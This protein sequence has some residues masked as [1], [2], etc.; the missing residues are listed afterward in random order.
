MIAWVFTPVG[1]SSGLSAHRSIAL[2]VTSSL[3]PRARAHAATDDHLRRLSP[4]WI[5]LRVFGIDEEMLMG[6]IFLRSTQLTGVHTK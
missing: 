5:P 4:S 1:I 6:V 2:Y 3:Y